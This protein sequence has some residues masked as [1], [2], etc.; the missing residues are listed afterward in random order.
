MELPGQGARVVDR[1]QWMQLLEH[2]ER[3]EQPDQCLPVLEDLLDWAQPV[4]SLKKMVHLLIW[5]DDFHA[6]ET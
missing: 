3:Q 4:C 5:Y 6:K 2:P 1:A